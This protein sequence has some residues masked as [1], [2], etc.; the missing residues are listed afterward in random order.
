MPRYYL[1]IEFEQDEEAIE[2]GTPPEIIR[3]Q[4]NDETEAKTLYNMLKPAISDRKHRAYFHICH[5]S[6]E[7]NAPCERIPIL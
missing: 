4:V 3:M 1:E 2:N 7:G 5:H 6:K